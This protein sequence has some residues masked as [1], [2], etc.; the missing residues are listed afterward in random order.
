MEQSTLT[1][2]QN[3]C[4][5]NIGKKR[6]AKICFISQVLSQIVH[7]QFGVTCVLL[8]PSIQKCIYSNL[9]LI[10]SV[11]QEILDQATRE[12]SFLISDL[13][14]GDNSIQ[15]DYEEEIDE[16]KNFLAEQYHQKIIAEFE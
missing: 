3:F 16:E 2:F 10:L 14:L 11:D 1:F 4:E 13:T 5:N 15:M 9:A 6:N 8:S 7:E 12:V